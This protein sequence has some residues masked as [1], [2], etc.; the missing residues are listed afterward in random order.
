MFAV[1]D[2]IARVVVAKLKVTLLAAAPT[3]AKTAIPEAHNLLLQGRYFA[4]RE[5]RADFL[6][7]LDC[8]TRA[9]ALDPGY[10]AAWSE[11]SCG[12]LPA[13]REWLR[14]DRFEPRGR[15]RRG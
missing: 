12:P 14:A 3:A 10:A 2:D 7:A 15:A 5:T 6:K 13:V 9:L 4:A 8:L 1:Q 11:L